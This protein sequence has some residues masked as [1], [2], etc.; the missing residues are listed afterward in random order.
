[1]FWQYDKVNKERKNQTPVYTQTEEELLKSTPN[2]VHGDS[3]DEEELAEIFSEGFG[4]K[5]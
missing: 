3:L 4:L 5:D 1:M 2:D